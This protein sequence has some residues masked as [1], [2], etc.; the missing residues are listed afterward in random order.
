[1]NDL[2]A[3]DEPP[4]PKSKRSWA[5][6]S[7]HVSKY[8]P[9][10]DTGGSHSDPTLPRST[11]NTGRST[12]VESADPSSATGQDDSTSGHQGVAAQDG[13]TTIRFTS[14]SE[15]GPAVDEKR[16]GEEPSP[17]D[18]PQKLSLGKRFL[19]DIKRIITSSWINWL[20]VFVPIGIAFGIMMK[21]QGDAGPISPNIVFAMNAIAIIPLAWMLCFATE[22]VA[23]KLGDTWGALLNVTFGNAVEL[24]I[25]IIAL[26]AK[27][28]RIVQA[29]LLGSILANLLLILGMCFIF[30]GLR[31]RE[32]LYNT[33]VSQMSA[34]LLALSVMSL[35]LPTVFHA[36]FSNAAAADRAVVK[37]SRGTSVVSCDQ[38]KNYLRSTDKTRFFSSYTFF[39]FSSS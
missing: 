5:S 21:I 24:I 34:G 25:F 6:I 16:G 30:G 22:S 19:H 9:F 18:Q 8:N 3:A 38:T 36:S 11:S 23:A 10:G 27:E 4:L 28:I 26:V 12:R 2:E 29:A 7:A 33:A 32:Q 15:T 13:N 1:M 14:T 20:L 37:V 31:F 35:L 17:I 39:I